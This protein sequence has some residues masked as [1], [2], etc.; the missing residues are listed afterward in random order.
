MNLRKF[1]PVV[2]ALL[3]CFGATSFVFA[4]SLTQGAIRGTVL[5]PSGA[6]IPNA[7]VNIRNDDTGQSLTSTTNS[8]GAFNFA[9]LP[10]GH[11]TLTTSA[12][13]YQKIAQGAVA[14]V[15]Q[16]TNIN[17]KLAVATQNQTVTVTA[18]GGV[19]ETVTPNV[20]TTM[21]TEQIQLVPNGGG[22]LSY[23]AQTAPGS[24]MN[25]QGGYGNFASNG[26]P[27]ITN[28]FTVNSMPENDPFLN[29]NNSGATNILLGQNDVSE[30]TV[31]SN[32]YEGEYS[33]AG[34]N[35]NYVS[36]S[37]TNAWHG[38]ATWRWNGRYVNA[39]NYFNKQNVPVTPRGF[40]ND[41][42][43]AASFGGPI[44]KDKTFFFV[45]TEGLRLIVPVS[46]PVKVPSPQFQAAVLANIATAQ[47]GESTLYQNMFTLYNNAPGAA[48]AANIIPGGGCGTS[49][50]V[51]G[52]GGAGT[53]CALEYNSTVNAGTHEWLLTGRLDQNIG[54][55]DKAFVHFRMD[56][57]LQATLTSPINPI[58]NATSF[59]PQYEGQLQWTHTL[60][61]NTVNSF[62]LNGSYY[63]AIFDYT[64]PA[65]ALALQPVEVAFS[66]GAFTPL[67]R[68]YGSFPQGRNVTQYGA[69]DDLSHTM[70]NHTI[71]I[72]ANMSRFDITTYGP[73][74]GS[75][76]VVSGESLTN[77]YSGIA[78]NF[79][80]AFPVRLEQPINLYNLGM[81]A[82]DT[83]RVRPSLSLT[84]T[85]RADR[86]S[87]P[88]CV[89]ACFN[90]FTNDFQALG[91]TVNTP[92]NQSILS[93]LSQALPGSYHPWTL[94]PRFGFNWSPFGNSLGVVLSGG[95]GIFGTTLPAGFV[96]SLVNNLPGDPSFT[97]S[98]RTFAP[99]LAGNA[100][101]AAIAAASALRTGFAS[102][103]TWADLNTAVLGTTGSAFSVPN[104]FNAAQG[105]HTPRFQ[106]WDLQLQKAL[107]TKTSFQLKYVGNHG[108]WEQINNNGLNA[109]CGTTAPATAD[110]TTYTPC[111]GGATSALGSLGFTGTTFNGLPTAP[112]D[113]RFNIITQFSSGYNSNYN[114]LTASLLRRFSSF[115][116]QLNYTWSHA[117]DYVSNAGVGNEP[118]NFNTNL[119][120][121]NPVNPFNVNQN[122]YGNADYDIRHYFSANYVYSTPK[123]WFGGNFFGHVL[124]D[125]TIAGTVFVHSGTPFTVVDGA[126]GPTLASY[127]YGGV[128]LNGTTFADQTGGYGS[129][130]TCGSQYSHT[131]VGCPGMV[132][133]FSP[134]TTGFGN[135]RRNQVY[136]PHFFNTDLTLS[137]DFPIPH[138]EKGRLTIGAT[139]YNLFNHP[140]FDQPV[141]DVTSG[142]FGQIL[143]T[144]NPPTSIYGA[145]LGADA[146]PRTLQSEIKLVW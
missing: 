134:L 142:S 66:G 118:F 71:K 10:P 9:L 67:G 19:L 34:A 93:G 23:I 75:L 73:G 95:F 26:L 143:T 141:Q 100:Q 55:K 60:S 30:A 52:F 140:N 16:V 44:K 120:V 127:G 45:D 110:P 53:P 4:Q 1:L 65:A 32:G 115:Q 116:F 92:Y 109:Y 54:D 107:G 57:G 61:A 31:V 59:Q 15:G 25:S 132:N 128:D 47:P 42:M 64:N 18:E 80:Q 94:E 3:L 105:F 62:N 38:N 24:A 11:Y 83:W 63:R 49:F 46:G 12:T 130:I 40:V 104:F 35:V 48:S 125:W 145:F 78:S 84:F 39:N 99:G 123:S 91:G 88:N 137:K 131:G 22:D 112:M 89:T 96:D 81:Y 146:S 14:S 58:F 21:S 97:V 69:V 2:L 36:R 129:I 135:E 50:A 74:F 113:P 72:G 122:M 17:V 85:F 102:G 28:N 124:A 101:S 87:N 114:G 13:N 119:S 86:N 108:I 111:L 126:V 29:L 139:A 41:N 51:A 5:D 37:G 79:T 138:W 90:R 8:T 103:A 7:T 121:T 76:P 117:L 43:W 68:G 20:T 136:G 82:E 6:A 98:G 33:Q 27:A 133:N 77:F 56:R 106:E 70:G 144:V